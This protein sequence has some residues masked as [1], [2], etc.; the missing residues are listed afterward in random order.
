V[1]K[2]LCSKFILGASRYSCSEFDADKIYHYG[3]LDSIVD[4]KQQI[5]KNPLLP[6]EIEMRGNFCAQNSFWVP[7]VI[8]AVSLIPTKYITLGHYIR[9]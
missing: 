8:P 7:A 3:A 9:S 6:I 4:N 5:S 1:W 2:L